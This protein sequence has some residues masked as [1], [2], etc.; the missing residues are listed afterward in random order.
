MRLGS[1]DAGGL[2]TRRE[3]RGPAAV[4]RLSSSSRWPLPFSRPAAN[5]G[6]GAT[7]TADALH[8]S[9]RW[10]AIPCLLRHKCNSFS[11]VAGGCNGLRRIV[12]L[13]VNL[14]AVAFG[15]C[16]GPVLAGEGH[17]CM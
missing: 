10:M 9:I 14:F 3:R 13:V 15:W 8:V 2:N 6:G 4:R 11:A 7:S 16:R 5:A 17:A 1:I 12:V